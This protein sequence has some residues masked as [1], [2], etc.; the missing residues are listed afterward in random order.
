MYMINEYYVRVIFHLLLGSSVK[1]S[2]PDLVKALLLLLLLFCGLEPPFES[3][4][5]SL[6]RLPLLQQEH[7]LIFSM[8]ATVMFDSLNS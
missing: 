1:S 4:L 3:S 2:R 7:F 5:M 8:V 6:L